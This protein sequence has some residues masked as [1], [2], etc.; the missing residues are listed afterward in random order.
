M[1]QLAALHVLQINF[2]QSVEAFQKEGLAQHRFD[3]YPIDRSRAFFA[4]IQF[5]NAFGR[6]KQGVFDLC[7]SFGQGDQLVTGLGRG[8]IRTVENWRW[9]SGGLIVAFCDGLV[10]EEAELVFVQIVGKF[11]FILGFRSGF[12]PKIIP[13]AQA[14]LALKKLVAEFLLVDRK[15]QFLG[16]ELHSCAF[17]TQLNGDIESFPDALQGFFEIEISERD[18]AEAGL[19]WQKN[20]NRFEFAV[21]IH[22]DNESG[23][24]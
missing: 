2:C 4:Y 22:S 7:D 10:E 3:I 20:R 14:I 24:H 9:C 19:A 17:I 12:I 5:D 13:K 15:T 11:N 6:G 21:G 16:A 23:E 8:E 18:T 1:D